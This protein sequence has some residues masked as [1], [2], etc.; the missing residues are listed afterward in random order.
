MENEIVDLER[1]RLYLQLL[2]RRHLSAELRLKVDSSDIVQ[3][4]MIRANRHIA[5]IRELEAGNRT[6][7]LR[8]IL[9]NRLRDEWRKHRFGEDS[10]YRE[11]ALQAEMDDSSARIEIWVESQTASPSDVVCSEERVLMV[12][13]AVAQ[14][15]T[16]QRL[17]VELHHLMELSLD[18]TA[19]EMGK[20]HAAVAGYLRRGLKRL[21]QV[22]KKEAF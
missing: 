6:A 4:T 17:A 9:V 11:Q 13:E 2:A 8:T 20:T 7:Y 3:E 18:K 12:I 22:L 15:P 19:T 10:L 16:E 21:R 5:K 1:Y 14:L